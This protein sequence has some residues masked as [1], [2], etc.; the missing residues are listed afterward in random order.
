LAAPHRGPYETCRTVEKERVNRW[1]ER[2]EIR[3]TICR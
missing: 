1:G 3:R 2:V